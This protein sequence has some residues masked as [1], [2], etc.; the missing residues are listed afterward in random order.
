L[1]VRHGVPA[2]VGPSIVYALCLLTLRPALNVLAG[3]I[4]A[5]APDIY[6]LSD[7]RRHKKAPAR[8]PAHGVARP[9][10]IAGQASL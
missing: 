1:A 3:T 2:P 9:S 6:R 5:A 10:N 8:V 4:I 7:F